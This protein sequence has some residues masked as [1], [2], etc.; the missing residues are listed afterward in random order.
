MRSQAEAVTHLK[1]VNVVNVVKPGSESLSCLMSVLW[2][3]V[4]KGEAYE[5]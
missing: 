1:T 5:A 2:P 3:H 4:V